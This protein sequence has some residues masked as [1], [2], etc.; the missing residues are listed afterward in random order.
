MVLLKCLIGDARSGSSFAPSV[1]HSV[2]KITRKI[3]RKV[4]CCGMSARAL[5]SFSVPRK[6]AW[7]V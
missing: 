1:L 7:T 3:K 2:P 4:R 5:G 6:E